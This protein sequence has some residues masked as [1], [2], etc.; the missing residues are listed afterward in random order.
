M[1][2]C[3]L[4]NLRPIFSLHALKWI[5]AVHI[6][7]LTQSVSTLSVGLLV[8][9]SVNLPPPGPPTSF[10][11]ADATTPSVVETDKEYE[12]EDVLSSLQE[13]LNNCRS[14]VQVR[15]LPAFRGFYCRMKLFVSHHHVLLTVILRC[16]CNCF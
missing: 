7:L 13:A 12:I 5:N 3:Q 6:F 4:F 8:P 2:I 14:F 16:L 1:L 11:R 15:E 10:Q 9:Q